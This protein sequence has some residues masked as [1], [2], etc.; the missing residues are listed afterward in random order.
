ML[1]FVGNSTF[2]SGALKVYFVR[3]SSWRVHRKI[4][5]FT[6]K[7]LWVFYWWFLFCFAWMCGCFIL[8]HGARI[9]SHLL[10]YFINFRLKLYNHDLHYRAVETWL[11]SHVYAANYWEWIQ[12]LPVGTPSLRVSIHSTE[13]P[14]Y[15]LSPQGALLAWL[16]GEALHLH[17]ITTFQLFFRKFNSESIVI[18]Y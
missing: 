14:C 16:R 4:T 15:S 17:T 13:C 2:L 12:V 6:D 3:S 1:P 5:S 7:C 11:F 9:W 18:Q 10:V 8:W